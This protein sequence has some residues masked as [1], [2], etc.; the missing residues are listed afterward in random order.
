MND[1]LWRMAHAYTIM[2]Q[3][4]T[5]LGWERFY[6]QLNLSSNDINELCYYSELNNSRD[7]ALCQIV[8]DILLDSIPALYQILK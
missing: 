2:G 4:L 6:N 3:A 5:I 1:A 8:R 7:F